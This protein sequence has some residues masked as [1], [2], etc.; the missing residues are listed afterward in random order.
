MICNQFIHF[1]LINE[2]FSPPPSTEATVYIYGVKVLERNYIAFSNGEIHLKGNRG[3]GEHHRRRLLPHT[4]AKSRSL[5]AV[6]ISV[7][8]RVNQVST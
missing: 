6:K 8:D 7:S 4:V 3:V 2:D 1:L 5:I